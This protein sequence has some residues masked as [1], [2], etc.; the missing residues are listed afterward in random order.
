MMLPTALLAGLFLLAPAATPNPAEALARRVEERQRG[1][2][3][4]K[5]RF[6]QSYRSGLLGREI[7]ERGTL[8]VKRP[9]RMRWEYRD[10]EAKTFVSDGKT[11]YFYVPA[12]KQVV[13]RDQADNHGI[14]ADLLSGHLDILAQFDVGIETPAPGRERL[15]LVPKKPDGEIERLYIEADAT[16]RIQAIEIMDAQGNRSRF[17]FQDIKEN[18]GLPDSLFHFDIPHGVEVVSG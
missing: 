17:D 1:V 16:A 2:L 13:V 8:A 18:V 3:D 5:G 12:D 4:L 7:V 15:R 6:V 10:P 9:G 11:F 14:T